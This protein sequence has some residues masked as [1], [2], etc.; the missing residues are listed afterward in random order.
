MIEIILI[1]L[2]IMIPIWLFSGA[3]NSAARGI[4]AVTSV[5]ESANNAYEGRQRTFQPPTEKPKK[6]STIGGFFK[7]VFYVILFFFVIGWFI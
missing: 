1:F 7:W 2:I 5:V 6:S 4:D 3:I